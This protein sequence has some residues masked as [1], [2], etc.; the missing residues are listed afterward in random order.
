M[1]KG[2]IIQN[3]ICQNNTY[4]YWIKDQEDH[5]DKYVYFAKNLPDSDGLNDSK[6]VTVKYHTISSNRYGNSNIIDNVEYGDYVTDI[7]IVKDFLINKLK[8]NKKFTNLII[9]T[10]QDS[11]LKVIMEETDKLNDL[12]YPN[13]AEQI[14]IIK[15]FKSKQINIEFYTALYKLGIGTKY[16]NIILSSFG[17]NIPVILKSIYDLYLKFKVPFQI[18]DTIAMKLNYDKNDNSRIE[19]FLIM[20]FKKFNQCGILY[21]TYE[22]IY[23]NINKLLRYPRPNVNNIFSNLIKITVNED[24]YYTNEKNYHYEKYIED[25]C[26]KLIKKIPV[27]IEFDKNTYAKNADKNQIDAISNAIRHS[28]SI[29]TGAPGTGKSYII[30]KIIKELHKH[31]KIYLLAPTGTAV[32][33]LRNENVN[34]KYN[35]EIRTLQSFLYLHKKNIKKEENKK[36]K[37]KKE[38]NEQ[39]MSIQELYSNYNEFIIIIDEMSM[40]DL[41]L[42]YKFMNQISIIFDKIRLIL[43]G[44]KN[45]L[46]SIRGGNVLNDLIISGQIKCTV[47]NKIYRQKK[48]V[49]SNNAKLVLN[50]ENIQPDDNNFIYIKTNTKKMMKINLFNVIKKY[51][52]NY[53]NS[54]I[55]IPLRKKGICV[56]K[57]N[58]ILQNYY[59]PIDSHSI[60]N[61]KNEFQFRIGDKI[62]HGKNNK[63][64][65]IYNGSILFVESTI[66]EK[67]LPNIRCQYYQ[68]ETKQGNYR[69]IEY[70]T[71]DEITD[72]KLNLAYA[73]TIHKAQ[74]KG[75]DTV[76]IIIH[77]SMTHCL[78]RNLL[79]TAITRAK[80]RCIIIGDDI[81]LLECKKI[82]NP[83]ITN[84]YKRY[85][86]FDIKKLLLIDKFFDLSN[87]SA[88]DILIKSGIDPKNL[89]EFSDKYYP[90]MLKLYMKFSR[91]GLFLDKLFETLNH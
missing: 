23:C 40:V 85:Y 37:N 16:H 41:Y 39:F 19:A 69:L 61:D 90:E 17:P 25:I 15:E 22:M 36:E 29:I 88:C 87:L 38:N 51:K 6:Y 42:F 77:S 12:F 54:S 9:N 30:N 7:S 78:Y 48:I 2:K 4:L 75:Y 55:L 13:I 34:S 80:E 67:S 18:C 68:S 33:R 21:E 31:N 62:M 53:E 26:D 28:I 82:M 45:Q 27:N 64:K 83:R 1:I 35:T 70:K 20:L 32:E 47:L 57:Y 8:I 49:I 84:L 65:D 14:N 56:D 11:T 5:C 46:P 76:V 81:G 91:D 3:K 44:D 43:I 59:N 50:G 73:T 66:N 74:G 60:Q 58:L 71:N 72:N 86:N 52:I 24:D 10:Y 63:D 89:E 79:Y